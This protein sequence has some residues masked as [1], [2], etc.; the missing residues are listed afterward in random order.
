METTRQ[1]GNKQHFESQKVDRELVMDLIGREMKT[2]LIY[3]RDSSEVS[4]IGSV[5]YLQ[6]RDST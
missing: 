6:K 2:S 3:T 4:G 1:E 5:R